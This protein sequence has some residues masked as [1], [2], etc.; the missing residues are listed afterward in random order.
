MCR[1]EGESTDSFIK[2]LNHLVEHCNNCGLHNEWGDSR[3]KLLCA[4]SWDSS[5]SEELQTDPELILA[6]KS[7]NNDSIKRSC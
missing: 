1:Q 7:N 4:C 6:W 5:L 2:S 3:P